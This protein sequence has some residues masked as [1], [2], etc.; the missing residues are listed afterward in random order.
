MIQK[1]SHMQLIFAVTFIKGIFTLFVL[2][3]IVFHCTK[4]QW[5]HHKPGQLHF[6]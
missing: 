5:K 6:D 4:M 1:C 2:T 3:L